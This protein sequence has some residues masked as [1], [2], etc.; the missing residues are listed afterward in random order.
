MVF[1]FKIAFKSYHVLLVLWIRVRKLLEYFNLFQPSL[2]P[3]SS[4]S[5][6]RDKNG[7]D[8]PYIVSLFLISLIA[9]RRLVF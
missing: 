5:A 1:V 8:C 9:T 7:M 4:L 6:R 3:R 2:L